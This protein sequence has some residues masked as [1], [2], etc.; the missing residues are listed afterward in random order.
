MRREQLNTLNDDEACMLFYI[1]NEISPSIIGSIVEYSI[2]PSIK[3]KKLIEKIISA[4]SKIK[5]EYK[6]IYISLQQKIGMLPIENKAD[7]VEELNY[8]I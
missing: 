4:E 2:I 6:P 3:H 1:V 7:I 8:E 5:E